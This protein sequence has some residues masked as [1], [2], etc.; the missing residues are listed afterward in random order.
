MNESL[1]DQWTAEIVSRLTS[2]VPSR[3]VM[4]DSELLR[5][6]A[7]GYSPPTRRGLPARLESIRCRFDIP[8]TAAERRR[9]E[10][11][12]VELEGQRNDVEAQ[13]AALTCE[14]AVEHVD[15][16]LR[17]RAAFELLISLVPVLP[18]ESSTDASARAAAC[19]EAVEAEVGRLRE[20]AELLKQERTRIR[21][22]VD[23]LERSGDSPSVARQLKADLEAV[24]L[25]HRDARENLKLAD[26]PR[27][28]RPG[29]P[30][31]PPPVP[32]E[33]AISPGLTRLILGGPH[34][35]GKY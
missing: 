9:Y 27:P 10:A 23:A 5:K 2:P 11:R 31:P 20:W 15:G 32:P 30:L 13:I 25:A 29:P 34:P 24:M 26:E 33:R 1:Y 18:V 35:L 21:Q 14:V 12:R 28:A 3:S 6:L 19:R 8:D 4:R 22:E 16:L 17:R 7:A